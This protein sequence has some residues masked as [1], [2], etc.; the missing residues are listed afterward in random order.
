M[1]VYFCV[2]PSQAEM[3]MAWRA[4]ICFFVPHT[5]RMERIS[6]M[7]QARHS[8]QDICKSRKRPVDTLESRAEMS[9]MDSLRRD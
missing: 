1:P 3:W 8:Q 9:P 7:A 4:S 5:L 2:F 6:E